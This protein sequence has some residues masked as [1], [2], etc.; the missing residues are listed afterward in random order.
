MTKKNEQKTVKF[1]I[2]CGKRIPESSSRKKLCSVRCDRRRRAYTRQGK[3]APYEHCTEPPLQARS[4]GELN[5]A[6][7]AEGLSYGRYIQK[8]YSGR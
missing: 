5:A 6:A 7:M 1:C 3:S 2:V 8:Y 4:L